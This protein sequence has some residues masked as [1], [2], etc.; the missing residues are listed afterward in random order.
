MST[1]SVI[2][3]LFIVFAMEMVHAVPV[4]KMPDYYDDYDEDI[5]DDLQVPVVPPQV[6]HNATDFQNY[7]VKF[8]DGYYDKYVRKIDVRTPKPSAVD[9]YEEMQS[10]QPV[11]Q[12]VNIHQTP[13]GSDYSALKR[14]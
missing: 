11:T 1:W 7:L 13:N 9:I 3:C 6:A 12:N 5:P 8:L 2:F 4:S 14:G 10:D